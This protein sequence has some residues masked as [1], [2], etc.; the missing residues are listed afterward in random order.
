MGRVPRV[1][2]AIVDLLGAIVVAVGAASLPARWLPVDAAAVALF[3]LLAAA[4]VG[5]LSNK[6][7]SVSVVRAASWSVLAIGLA[8]VAAL[9]TAIAFLTGIFGASSR[10]GIVVFALVIA[11]IL[12]YLVLFPLAQL[13]LFRAEPAR[14]ERT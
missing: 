8:L 9:S 4:G 12:P 1:A 2:F 13:F 14:E 3:A 5:L 7:W 6:P 11:L 10:G